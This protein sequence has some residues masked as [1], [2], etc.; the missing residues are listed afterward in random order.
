MVLPH[1]SGFDLAGRR[2]QQG[3]VPYCYLFMVM[4]FAVGCIVDVPLSGRGPR[5]ALGRCAGHGDSDSGEH[6]L[7]W[8]ENAELAYQALNAQLTPTPG[9]PTIWWV[10]VSVAS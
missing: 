6:F 10:M 1:D 8:N 3:D 5:L 4:G 7:G 2:T 9:V